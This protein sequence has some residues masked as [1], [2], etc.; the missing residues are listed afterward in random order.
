MAA[1]SRANLWVRREGRRLEGRA[2]T[3]SCLRMT[4]PQSRLP[5]EPSSTLVARPAIRASFCL[6]W[7]EVR[8]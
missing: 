7:A 8:P 4:L 5:S 1:P 2:R 6:V 3:C